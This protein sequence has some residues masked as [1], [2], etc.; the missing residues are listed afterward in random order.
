L[1]LPLI[2][3]VYPVFGTI[4]SP[5]EE[6]RAPS[7]LPQP[8]LLKQVNG[9][10]AVALNQWFDDRFGLRDLFIRA[11]NQIDYSLFRTS[12]KVYVGSHGWLFQREIPRHITP[13]ALFAIEQ[14]FVSLARRL[15]E[16]GVR[17]IVVGYPRK[18]SVYP[19]FAPSHM[20]L[21]RAD[22]AYKHLRQFLSQQSEFTFIDAQKIIEREKANTTEHLYSQNDVH[23]TQVAQLEVVK[24]IIEQIARAEGRP[25]I[26]WHENFTLSHADRGAGL[27]SEDRFLSLLFPQPESVPYYSGTYD[28]GQPEADGQW[29]VPDP[30]VLDRA[31][32]GIGRAFDWQFQSA[33]ELCP[34]RLPGMVLFGN[35]FSDAYWALGLHR[36]FCFIRRA[37]TPISRFKLFFDTMPAATKY[38]I[39]QYYE[40]R[41]WD[42][43]PP[44][45]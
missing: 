38:F 30:H 5:V 36:Y 26:R 19:E 27:G 2:Q 13:A 34:Q 15:A 41:L 3:T 8:E 29:L 11:K 4:V 31:D 1:V 39:F 40:P 6:R 44:L 45:G 17:L 24:A 20:P 23:I 42:E 28:I 37:R 7:P 18:S 16:T 10:F 35:S 43:P 9:E 21:P 33:P 22:G 12:R 25:D 32:P 14:S